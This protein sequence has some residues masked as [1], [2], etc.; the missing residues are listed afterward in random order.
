MISQ[1]LNHLLMSYN[2][3]K[4]GHFVQISKKSGQ[5]TKTVKINASIHVQGSSKAMGLAI[6]TM[7]G[8]RP[9]SPT[10]LLSFLN[11]K[12]LRTHWGYAHKVDD[13]GPQVW[14]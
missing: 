14:P 11:P 4:G 12:T 7:T 1:S 6:R 2:H 3:R 9:E 5:S 8:Q 10:S 13:H